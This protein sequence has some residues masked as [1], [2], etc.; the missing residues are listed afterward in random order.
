MAV[1]FHSS[2]I[3]RRRG[4]T[5][6]SQSI[7]RAFVFAGTTAKYGVIS[8]L[9]VQSVFSGIEAFFSGADD[10]FLNYAPNADRNGFIKDL[11]TRYEIARVQA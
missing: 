5:R 2:A 1:R 8:A 9:L 3:H 6:D 7:E 10:Y 4:L 11:G